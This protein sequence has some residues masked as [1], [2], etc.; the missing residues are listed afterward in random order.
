MVWFMPRLS[1]NDWILAAQQTLAKLGVDAVRVE[2]L[3]RDLGVSKG[4]FYWHFKDREALLQA[5]LEDWEAR[6]TSAIIAQVEA[7]AAEPAARLL[8]LIERTF[9]TT[10]DRQMF[11]TAMRA[12]GTVDRKVGARVQRIDKRRIDYVAKLLKD[13]GLDTQE[14]GRRAR[15]LYTTLVGEFLMR[16]HGAAALTSEAL[17]SL[18]TLLLHTPLPEQPKGRRR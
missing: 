12:W 6:G 7:A 15:I 5:L 2:T 4:S 13:A 10:S 9:G 14:A 8:V 16:S 18:H 1:A 3:A 11:E 17:R